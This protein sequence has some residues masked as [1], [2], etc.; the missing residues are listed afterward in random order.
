MYSQSPLCARSLTPVLAEIWFFKSL[1]RGCRTKGPL[2]NLG[3]LTVLSVHVYMVLFLD[4]LVEEKTRFKDFSC[5]YSTCMYCFFSVIG[6]F[7]PVSTSRWMQGKKPPRC[8]VRVLYTSWMVCE[9]IYRITTMFR[10][11]IYSNRQRNLN[12]AITVLPEGILKSVPYS[13][14]STVSKNVFDFLNNTLPVHTQQVH[15]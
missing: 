2:P 13:H 4:Y 14:K 8:T 10:S 5:R 15:L 1:D 12:G 11:N 7:Y 3:R 6:R 9:T